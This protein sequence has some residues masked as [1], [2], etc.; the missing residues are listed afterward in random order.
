MNT[1]QMFSQ[2]VLLGTV[3]YKKRS[4]KKTIHRCKVKIN[5]FNIHIFTS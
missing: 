2:T 1:T 5:H 4:M 3:V